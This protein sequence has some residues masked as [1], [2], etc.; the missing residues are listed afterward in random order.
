MKQNAVLN[1]LNSIPAARQPVGYYKHD[2]EETYESYISGPKWGNLKQALWES[3]R[4]YGL[5]L[6]ILDT[7]RGWLRETIY[8][9]VTGSSKS[10][11]D[12][13]NHLTEAV[14]ENNK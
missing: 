7:D 12:F 13:S 8:F 2:T 14:K 6:K 3:T 10:L 5:K 4:Y 1:F 9:E 11:Q